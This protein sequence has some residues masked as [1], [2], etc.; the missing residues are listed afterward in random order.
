MAKTLAE[1]EEFE[2]SVQFFEPAR[3]CP[4]GSCI[5]HRSAA[6]GGTILRS[7]R[8][9]CCGFRPSEAPETL[10]GVKIRRNRAN[11]GILIEDF[12]LCV[13]S[14]LGQCPDTVSYTHLRAHETRH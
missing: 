8:V 14:Q 10:K 6:L 12:L 2:L 4:S 5:H 1:R 13:V 7:P 3:A 11:L 9:M